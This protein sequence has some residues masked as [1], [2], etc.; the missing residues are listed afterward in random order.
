MTLAEPSEFDVLPEDFLSTG[1]VVADRYKIA[2]PL[3]AGGFAQVYLATHN[4]VESLR[5]AIKVLHPS[6]ATPETLARFRNEAQLLARLRNRHTVRLTDFGVTDENM[7]FLVMEYVEGTPLDRIIYAKGALGQADTARVGIGVLKSLVEAHTVGIIHRDLKPANIMLVSEMGERHPVPRV[8]DFGIAKVL[9]GGSP[10]ED[11]IVRDDGSY[12]PVV[13]CTPAYAAPELLR[14]RPE[15]PTDIYALGLVMV[16]MLDGTPPYDYPDDEPA[17]SPH[18]WEEPVPLGRRAQ[19]SVLAPILQKA[20]GKELEDRYESASAMLDDLEKAYDEIRRRKTKSGKTTLDSVSKRP[21]PPARKPHPSRVSR[22][23]NTAMQG[24]ANANAIRAR[25]LAEARADARDGSASASGARPRPDLPSGG[26]GWAASARNPTQPTRPA[27]ERSASS[28]GAAAASAIAPPQSISSRFGGAARTDVRA[29]GPPPLAWSGASS[30][31]DPRAA[32]MPAGNARPT[33]GGLASV[34][35]ETGPSALAAPF[36]PTTSG[37]G[38]RPA[39]SQLSVSLEEELA[40][41][42]DADVPELPA[43][44]RNDSR[45]SEIPFFGGRLL[46]TRV[47]IVGVV[48]VMLAI[49]VPAAITAWS[50][51]RYLQAQE[52]PPQTVPVEHRQQ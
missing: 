7:A 40:T 16:E 14:G 4:E 45:V 50:V 41:F 49:I 52:A 27:P 48:I 31:F 19:K 9:G 20:L 26:G 34:P 47:N 29:D 5:V 32:A 24:V 38:N 8:L 23:V 17:A 35:S 39:S 6:H 44:R 33:S 10:V 46:S 30:H 2:Y 3:G 11:H 43:P 12:E 18:L 37:S 51:V 42:S 22:F 1:D 13:Y 25:E 15:F 36:L 28:S 21:P